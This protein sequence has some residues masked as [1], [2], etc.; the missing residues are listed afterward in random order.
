M[1]DADELCCHT[2]ADGDAEGGD[3]GERDGVLLWEVDTDG[4]VD[5]DVVADAD[6]DVL[7]VGEAVLLGNAEGLAVP[8]AVALGLELELGDKEG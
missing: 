1:G 6:G 2:E 7:I 3:V 4:D 5:G 8:V